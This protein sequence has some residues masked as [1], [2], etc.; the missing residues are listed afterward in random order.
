MIPEVDVTVL[1]DGPSPARDRLDAVISEAATDIGFLSLVSVP[2]ALG[3]DDAARVDLLR[4]FALPPA[5]QRALWKRNFAPENPNLYRGWFPLHSGKARTREGFD[6]GPDLVRAFATDGAEDLLYEATPLP[7][8]D[9][10]PGW[11]ETARRYF[12]GMELLGDQLLAALARGMGLEESFFQGLFE[13]GISTLRLLHYLPSALNR[14]ART[15]GEVPTVEHR[16]RRHE[17]IARAHVDSGLLTILAQCGIGG[18]QAQAND[19]AWLDV[20]V[21]DNG[22][23]V[24]FGGLLECWSGRRVK[25]TRHRVLSQGEERFSVPF[26]FEP[27]ADALIA[28]LPIDGAEPFQPFLFGDHLWATTTK[29]PENFGLEA[30]RPP[31]APYQDPLGSSRV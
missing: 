1:L 9:L 10:L 30:L 22:F 19:G 24:N 28:P 16:G 13:N 3:V 25:A 18:L 6:M 11:R 14:A 2:A 12:L 17:Q 4:L 27:R 31:R 26:F 20:P 5:A 21:R 23:A 8:E 29:F 15:E 7:S